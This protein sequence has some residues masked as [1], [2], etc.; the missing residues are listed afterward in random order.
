MTGS[1]L[2]QNNAFYNYQFQFRNN[3]PRNHAVLQITE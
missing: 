1:A 3:Y 2:E